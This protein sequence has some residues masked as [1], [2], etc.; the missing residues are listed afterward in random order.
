MPILPCQQRQAI[1][2]TAFGLKKRR[3][4]QKHMLPTQ[5]SQATHAILKKKLMPQCLMDII[6]LVN[7]QLNRKHFSYKS[8]KV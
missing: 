1:A 7:I 8:N 2:G 4:M 6:Q 5:T 3:Q